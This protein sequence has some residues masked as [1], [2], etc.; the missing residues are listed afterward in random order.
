MKT[1]EMIPPHLQLRDMQEMQDDPPSLIMERY[2]L[3]LFYHKSVCILHRKYWKSTATDTL[4]STYFYSRKTCITSAMAL[5]DHQATMHRSSQPSGK[6]RRMKWC[7]FSLANHDFLLAAMIVCLDL[8]SIIRSDPESGLPDCIIS[9]TEKIDTIKRSK[10]IWTEVVGECRDAR[11]AVDIL[12][13]VLSKLSARFEDKKI[14]NTNGTEIPISASA[15]NP[16][17]DSLRFS[18]YFTDQFGL[19]IPLIADAPTA[20]NIPME[21]SFLESFGSDPDLCTDFDW[22]RLLDVLLSGFC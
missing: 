1:R 7:H 12:T 14:L 6:M 3:Q 17:A 4:Q 20:D 19:G 18:P 21:G 5:L 9:E 22:V 2:I 11:R 8:M 10:A 16:T 15:T 13:G